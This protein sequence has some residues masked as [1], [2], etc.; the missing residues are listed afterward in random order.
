VEPSAENNYTIRIAS[1]RGYPELVELLLQDPRVDPSD[2]DNEAIRI[3][4][5]RGHPNIV[6]LLLLD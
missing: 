1:E 2:R 6:E 4:S 5:E 3:A